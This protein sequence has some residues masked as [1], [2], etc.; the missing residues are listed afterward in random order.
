MYMDNNLMAGV[1]TQE[2]LEVV[3]ML[4][5][6]VAISFQNATLYKNLQNANL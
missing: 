2:R 3:K 1:F 4:S 6:Q 5:V